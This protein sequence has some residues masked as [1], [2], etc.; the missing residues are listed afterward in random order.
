MAPNR[1]SIKLR[2]IL[3][4]D[5]VG[6]SRLVSRKEV[7][8]L[9]F[10]EEAFDLFGKAATEYDGNLVKTTGDGVVVEFS[11]PTLAVSF[12][13]EV[14]KRAGAL[15]HGL[16]QEALFR[17]GIHVGEVEHA[18][19]DIYG[20]AVNI[21][22]RLEPLATPGGVCIS[23]DVFQH[24]RR[25]PDLKFISNGIRQLKNISDRIATYN[26][27]EVA[28]EDPRPTELEGLEIDTIDGLALSNTIGEPAPVRSDRVRALIGYLA[29]R[30]QFSDT[31]ERITALLWPDRDV[32][33]ARRA[34]SQ[35]VR[36]AN[37]LLQE[38]SPEVLYR[39][40]NRV[41]F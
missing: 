11:S 37:D 17:I 35:C 7:A 8:T 15:Q 23:Q 4:A 10:M 14:Q 22:A 20:H 21:A 9:T 16:G 41:G 13:I 25:S 18:E 32:K 6:Y 34:M 33:S 2:A 31:T 40:N 19:G 24:V 29:L 36:S 30:P 5:L 38:V 27:L 12:A 1:R 39:Q 3:F 26:V 28:D